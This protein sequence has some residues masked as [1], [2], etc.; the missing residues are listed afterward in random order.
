MA[1]KGVERWEVGGQ[2]VE[3]D[4]MQMLGLLQVFEA[5]RPQVAQRR[6]LWQLWLGQD[7]GSFGEQHLAAMPHR[8]DARRAH[9]VQPDVLTTRR[10]MGRAGVQPHPDL[11]GRAIGP[12]MGSQRPLR[13]G[14]RGQRAGSSG[15]GDKEG[16]PLGV[17][18]SPI[19]RRTR[20]PHQPMMLRLQRGIALAA[21]LLEQVG[22]ALDLTLPRL[23][24]GD[25]R[26]SAAAYATAPRRA[27]PAL[28][29]FRAA[30]WSRCRLVPQSGQVCQ[31]MD[32]PLATS[33][34]QPEPIWLVSAGGTATTE[35]P[36]HTALKLRMLKNALHPASA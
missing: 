9:H 18:F 31:R 26:F 10:H 29:R 28:S 36:A 23:K 15:E 35:R 1:I 3:H 16:V 34:P 24:P 7:A 11:D 21:Q 33:T 32:T 17:H 14:G 27:S 4:L 30:W 20:R 2:T 22:R 12:G 6:A 19:V 8:R 25:A 5:M 13:L